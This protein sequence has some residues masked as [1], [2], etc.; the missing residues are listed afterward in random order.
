MLLSACGGGSLDPQSERNDY[1]SSV[2]EMQIAP[3]SI[4]TASGTVTVQAICSESNRF[5][6]E[7]PTWSNNATTGQP[8]FQL[9]TVTSYPNRFVAVALMD[10]V[11]GRVA[12][13]W[14]IS[15]VWNLREGDFVSSRTFYTN[16]NILFVVSYPNPAF[17]APA[18]K[19]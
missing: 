19:L 18:P 9:G 17:Q 5:E 8:T 14:V 15:T 1:G 16:D 3:E 13:D 10:A 11:G 12:T 7:P 6:P 4:S 2:A